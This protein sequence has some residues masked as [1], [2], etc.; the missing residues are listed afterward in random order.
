[1]SGD[2]FAAEIPHHDLDVQMDPGSRTLRVQDSVAI[3]GLP[4]MDLVLASTFQVERVLVDGSPAV[5]REQPARGERKRWRIALGPPGRARTVTIRYRGRLDALPVADQHD[6][7]GGLPPWADGRGSFLPGGSGWYPE[8]AAAR[9]F[10]YRVHLDLPGDQRGVVPG[11]LLDEGVEGGR[12]RA[13]FVFAHPAESI[14]LIAGPYGVTERLVQR[15]GGEPLR[16]RTYFHQELQDLAGEYLSAVERYLDFYGRWIG[17]YPFTEFSVVSSPLPTGFGMPTLTYLGMDVLRLLFIR[18][19]SLGHEVLHNWWGNGV[20]VDWDHGNW[21]EGLTAFMA[22]YIYKEQQGVDAGRAARL[23]LLRDIAA[24]P[25]GQDTPLR[26]F[27]SRTHG[28]SQVVGYHKGT[29]LFLMLRD[30]IGFAAFDAGVRD[31][32]RVQQ[33]RRASWA[34]LQRAFEQA[35]G[36]GLGQF[37]AQW[38]DRR[39]APAIRIEQATPERVGSGWRVRLT[40]IQ[41]RTAYDLRV[42]VVVETATGATPHTLALRQ[43]RQGFIL[44]VGSR[45][46]SVT[47]DPDYRLCRRLGPAEAPPILRDVMLN[48]ATATLTLGE[49]PNYVA[50]SQELARR[51]LDYPSRAANPEALPATT[52]LLLI[53]NPKAVDE[54]L[55]RQR[56]P[57]RPERL[58]DRGTAQVWTARDTGGLPL[59]LVSA[60]SVEALRA[61]LRPLPHYGR[62]SYLVFQGATVTDRGIW[63]AEPPAWRFADAGE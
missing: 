61:L 60:E 47:L 5:P 6:V 41:D 43:E 27:T 56:L 28:T 13:T 23:E 34:D 15:E 10:T 38:L 21:S 51:L 55:A 53:G 18:E 46:R 42:P 49:D 26:R 4:T 44:D 40:L 11:R 52:P 17:P 8:I 54:F 33:F 45:P 39:G 9:F 7:L 1:M 32:W 58:Q 62:Q 22:D 20:Y 35:S 30:L 59:V 3:Q 63:P 12:Y 48:P 14:D 29:L 24:V 57:A 50:A 36:K 31:F 37:F 16:L 25:P 19:T 2:A